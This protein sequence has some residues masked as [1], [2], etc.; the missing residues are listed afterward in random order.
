M[1]LA[2]I[3]VGLVDDR[4]ASVVEATELRLLSPRVFRTDVP[5]EVGPRRDTLVPRHVVRRHVSRPRKQQPNELPQFDLV[6]EERPLPYACS[7]VVLATPTP[8]PVLGVLLYYQS[9]RHV[10]LHTRVRVVYQCCAR[11]PIN[12]WT[13]IIIHHQS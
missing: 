7:S 4:L 1:V 10:A 9:A 11:Q 6:L 12:L 2:T 8:K 3:K 5:D 13:H